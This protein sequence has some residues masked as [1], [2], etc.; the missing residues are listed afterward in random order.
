MSRRSKGQIR[1]HSRRN[2]KRRKE[3]EARRPVPEQ[4]VRQWNGDVRK[5][6]NEVGRFLDPMGD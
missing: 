1:R 2:R 3:R 6:W 5:W 4:F